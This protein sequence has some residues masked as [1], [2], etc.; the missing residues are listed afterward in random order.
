MKISLVRSRCEC[1]A[2]LV[3]KLDEQ[4]HVLQA[5]VIDR[6][7]HEESAPAH[8]IGAQRDR[9]DVGWLCGVCG[10]N[11][12]RSFAVDALIWTEEAPPPPPVV[13]D[14]TPATG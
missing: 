13:A 12:L 1:Q 3:A 14:P 9:F 5:Y 6:S 4:R 10:R 2:R 7:N 11:V 8:S